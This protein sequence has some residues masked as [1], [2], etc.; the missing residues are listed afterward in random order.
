MI[1]EQYLQLEN[2]KTERSMNATVFATGDKTE[3]IDWLLDD[4]DEN[5][6]TARIVKGVMYCIFHKRFINLNEL[7]KQ[8]KALYINKGFMGS[9][10]SKL[11]PKDF[12]LYT[13]AKL[14]LKKLFDSETYTVEI[15]PI[16]AAKYFYA[17]DYMQS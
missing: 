7:S 16:S 10:F 12:V 13:S 2:A 1:F 14:I 4:S 3:S 15:N 8:V 5:V 11:D 6:L 17:A 9:G